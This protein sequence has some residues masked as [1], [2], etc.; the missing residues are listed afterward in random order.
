M[1]EDE[2]TNDPVAVSQKVGAEIEAARKSLQNLYQQLAATQ[3]TA[4]EIARN[5]VCKLLVERLKLA[6]R[7][8][9]ELA[10]LIVIAR[11]SP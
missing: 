1:T 5:G 11:E 6:E 10:D 9:A 3:N 8:A 4:K 2:L 7:E